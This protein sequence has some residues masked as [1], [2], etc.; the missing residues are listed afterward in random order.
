MKIKLIEFRTNIFHDYGL[1]YSHGQEIVGS[2]E[3]LAKICIS[4]WEKKLNVKTY[5]I[6]HTGDMVVVVDI[7][8]FQDSDL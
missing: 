1:P 4:F 7:Y 5:H 2:L 3:D 6:H 8:R